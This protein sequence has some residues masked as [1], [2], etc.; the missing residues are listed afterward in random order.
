MNKSKESKSNRIIA[1]ILIGLVLIAGITISVNF[2]RAKE[3]LKILERQ[4]I[5][6][7]A[8]NK[9]AQRIDLADL[10]E[11]GPMEFKAKLKSSTMIKSREHNYTGVAISD[12]LEYAGIDLADMSRIIVESFDGYRVPL[13]IE[14][15]MALENV[16]L[17][18]KDNGEYL[19]SYNEPDGQGPYMIV[20]KGDTF[21]QRWAKY[22]TGMSIE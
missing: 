17:V 16:F 19:K 11:I 13:K 8:D 2:K 21:S 20:V 7:S 9:E 12:I 1:A 4:E 6:I 14:E 3:Q 10:L 22:V 15:I 5:V 18:Y